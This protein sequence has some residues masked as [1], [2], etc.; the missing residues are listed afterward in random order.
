MN[1]K[2]YHFFYI[3]S[4]KTRWKIVNSLYNSDKYVTQI[5]KDINEEQSKISHS[6]KLLSKCKIV[7]SER[8]GKYIKYSLNKKTIVP[9]ITILKEHMKEFC[10]NKCKYTQE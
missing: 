6:L 5:C 4:N 8:Q 3:I 1:S 9:L 10:N 7:F 2:S